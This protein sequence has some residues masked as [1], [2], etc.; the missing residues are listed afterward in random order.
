MRFPVSREQNRAHLTEIAQRERN[1]DAYF[2]MIETIDGQHVGYIN[3]FDCD[4]RV[5]RFK[6]AVMIKRPFWRRGYA[7]EA[8]TLVLRYY[9]RELR[10]QKV[11]VLVY[12]FNEQSIRLHQALGFSLDGRLR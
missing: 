9:F 3:T 11:A 4:R 1:D 8:V 5:G 12:S 2:W 6:Y 10:Y 7:R